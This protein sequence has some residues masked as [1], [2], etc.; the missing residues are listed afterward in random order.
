MRD[1]GRDGAL[2][3][4]QIAYAIFDSPFGRVLAAAT[5][6]GLCLVGLGEDDAALEAEL[7]AD[8]PRAALRRDD[9]ALAGAAEALAAYLAGHGPCADLPLDA[10]GTPF[11]RRVWAALCAIPCGETRTYGQIAEGLGMGRGAARAVGAACGANP[12]SLVIPCHR[13]VGSDGKLHGFR[14][15]IE[16]K[17]RLLELERGDAAPPP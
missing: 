2:T 14:W 4:Q 9:G 7:R 12:V 3:P 17:R 6:R 16:R 13:A 10:P 11:Q 1:E 15:G 5:E 8:Y